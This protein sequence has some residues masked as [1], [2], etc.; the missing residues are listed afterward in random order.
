MIGSAFRDIRGANL[1]PSIGMKK[2]G[3]HIRVN[4]GQTPFVFDIDGMVA[5]S[6][7]LCADRLR[8]A[9]LT[10]ECSKRESGCLTRSI[11]ETRR[12]SRTG[13]VRSHSCRS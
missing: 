9:K 12:H 3:E 13:V 1:Y 10:G 8:Y 6:R 5:V 11:V 7:L 4:F 2:L